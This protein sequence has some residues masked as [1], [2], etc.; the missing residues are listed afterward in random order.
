MIIENLEIN[1]TPGIVYHYEII[2]LSQDIIEWMNNLFIV[3]TSSNRN[4]V[5][6]TLT[7]RD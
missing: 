2:L 1:F 6:I 7:V 3:F 5:I 4:F